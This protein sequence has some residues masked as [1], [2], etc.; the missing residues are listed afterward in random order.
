MRRLRA[1]ILTC[2]IAASGVATGCNTSIGPA[3]DIDTWAFCGPDP[4]SPQSMAQ[5]RSL[6]VDAAIDA[7][8]GPCLPPDWSTYSP[9]NP[10]LRYA[11]VATY[12][13][14]VRQAA[15][16]GMSVIVYDARV[17]STDPAVRDQAIVDW[18]PWRHVVR[19][20]D[21]GDEFDPRS[22]DWAVLIE[23]WAIVRSEVTPRL[24][25]GPFTNHLGADWVFD[26]ALRDLPGNEAHFSFDLY[27][28]PASIELARGIEESV[29]HLM[30]A[31]N[32]LDHGPYTVTSIGLETAIADH[33]EIACDSILVFGGVTPI[34]T[35]GFT[36][37]SLVDD[38]G[39]PTPLAGAVARATT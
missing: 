4:W 27:D 21:M 36:T 9:A 39:R 32:A 26:A 10:G 14:L 29:G 12:F 13:E 3:R 24:G 22:P 6:H 16:V 20:F 37:P 17:W 1:L 38:R 35:P 25:I 2:L 18:Y 23:R 15:Q 11:D 5:L 34:N 33:V 31:V 8:F 7:V 19:A 28:V 30:C